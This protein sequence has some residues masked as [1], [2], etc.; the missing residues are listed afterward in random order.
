MPDPLP[1]LSNSLRFAGVAV[2]TTAA[3][4]SAPQVTFNVDTPL[5]TVDILP[6]D[7]EALD[8]NGNTSLR[9]AIQE[10]NALGGPATIQLTPGQL[11][12]L[13][14]TGPDEDAALTGDLDVWTDI[15]LQGRGASVN[16]LGQGRAFD[17]MYRKTLEVRDLSVINGEVVDASGGGFRNSGALMLLD[18]QISN[19]V[20]TGAGASGGGV[21]NDRGFLLLDGTVIVTC[22]SE[23][24]GGAI[25]TSAGSVEII[26][27]ELRLNETGPTPGNGG[28]LHVTGSGKVRTRTT[29]VQQNSAASEGGGFWNSSTGL[30]RTTLTSFDDN[31]ALG[32][33]ADNGGGGLFNDGGLLEISLA[34]ITRNRATQGSGSGG[35]VFNNGGTLDLELAELELNQAARAGGALELLGGTSD[36]TATLL[37]DNSAMSSPGNG[38]AAHVSGAGITRFS[39]CDVLR[40]V[41]SAEGGGLWNSN[42][43]TMTVLACSLSDNAAN[44]ADADQ[45]GGALF[46]DGGSLTVDLCQVNS[47]MAGG[48]AGSGGAVFNNAGDLTIRNSRF[49]LNAS[50]RAG[51]AI[52]ALEGTT[53]LSRTALTGNITGSAPGNGGGLHLTGAGFVTIDL[54]L[55]NA[56]SAAAEGGGLWNSATGTMTVTTS[57]ITG[58]N[59]PIGSD[60]FNDGGTFTIDGNRVP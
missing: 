23:R 48:T 57:D 36:I 46:N 14:R 4:W 49:A 13:N 45:G 21:F 10:A 15:V 30:M 2:A 56:N 38:G 52:E 47:N 12:N 44:G 29:L 17:V 27:S 7:G 22:R 9:A 54:C 55:I 33:D 19:C 40:N 11:Y 60:V 18:C 31:E 34:T 24:A 5:D 1:Y 50:R 20:A 28:A 26:R 51:G 32:T 37:A 25:E 16:A 8:A 59:A 3:A 53:M 6:G 35:G 41:A 42:T 43:G 39:Q 58:N